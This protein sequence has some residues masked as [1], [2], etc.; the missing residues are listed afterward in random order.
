M[1]YIFERK[2]SRR[3]GWREEAITLSKMFDDPVIIEVKSII[4]IQKKSILERIKYYVSSH[5]NATKRT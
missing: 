5:F 3:A 1:Y 4:A 2:A